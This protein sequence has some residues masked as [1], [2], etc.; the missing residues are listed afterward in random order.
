MDAQRLLGA[1]PL[2]DSA[3]FNGRKLCHVLIQNIRR[4]EVSWKEALD[5]DKHPDSIPAPCL[6]KD[7]LASVIRQ[8]PIIQTGDRASYCHEW[9]LENVGNRFFA[10]RAHHGEKQ[11]WHTTPCPSW[12]PQRRPGL[13]FRG[14]VVDSARR[15]V[16]KAFGICAV[17]RPNTPANARS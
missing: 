8:C 5:A 1:F 10:K 12:D 15:R 7:I 4:Y 2:R 17:L 11:D 13:H 9:L 16:P 14:V 6:T 3:V